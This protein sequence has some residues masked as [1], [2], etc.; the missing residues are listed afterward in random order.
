MPISTESRTAKIQSI[1]ESR[2]PI[3]Q[4]TAETINKLNNLKNLLEKFARFLPIVLEKEIPAEN[5]TKIEELQNSLKK[6]TDEHIPKYS[7]EIAQIERR[8]S[9]PTLNIGVVGN[10]R[11]GKS[12][13]LQALTGLSSNEIPSAPDGHCT[14]AP[15]IIINNPE[16]FADIEFYGEKE[17]MQEVIFPYYTKLD[18]TPQPDSFSSFANTPIPNPTKE[19]NATKKELYKKLIDRQ[20][21]CQKYRKYLNQPPCRINKEQIREYIAQQDKDKKLL[22]N[23]IAVKMATIYCPFKI[24]DA[25]KISVCD[26]PGLGD[27]VCGAEENLIRNIADNLDAIILLK[28]VPDGG[29]VKP[30]DT[31]LYDLIPKA[32]PEFSPKDWSHFI[33]NRKNSDENSSINY[34][35]EQ[36]KASAIN[37]RRI[38]TVD[39]SCAQDVLTSFDQILDDIK[40]NQQSLDETLYNKRFENIKTLVSNLNEYVEKVKDSLPKTVAGVGVPGKFDKMFIARW[41]KTET[42][43]ESINKKYQERCNTEDVEFVQK[44]EEIENYLLHN[45]DFSSK[46]KE[47]DAFGAEICQ[48]FGNKFHEL[49]IDLAT[50]FDQLDKGLDK[51]ILKVRQE[52]CDVFQHADQG[53]LENIFDVDLKID[54]R[55]WLLKLADQIREIDGGEK[56]AQTIQYFADASFSFRNHLLYRIRKNIDPLGRN[57]DFAI[58]PQ[59]TFE[60]AYE[61]ARMAWEKAASDCCAALQSLAKEPNRA[62]S[63]FVED[64]CDG[65]L[66]TG[67]YEEAKSVWRNF[68]EPYRADIWTDEYAA[69]EENTKLRDTWNKYIKELSDAVEQLKS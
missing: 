15:S 36:L 38:I 34:F 28:L 29:I 39:V 13:F 21:H 48:Y 43:L 12:T 55:K 42:G 30:E 52:V 45:Y 24:P 9:R 14:G 19:F 66:R 67:G 49:R 46:L 1:I 31:Q 33:I 35:E 61:K 60:M 53:G 23:W 18:L 64:F 59:D 40:N 57:D 44:L 5:K 47:S 58:L 11:Q 41:S 54:T 17:F 69:F 2:K 37:V 27:F 4:K 63:A 20:Q 3:A 7:T 22:S 6:F 32:I 50:A 26:T 16:T 62:I 65:V 10:A 25:G 56:I 51:I 8:F 68:Y